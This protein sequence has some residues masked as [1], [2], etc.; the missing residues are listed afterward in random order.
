MTLHNKVIINIIPPGESIP[1]LLSPPLSY[2]MRCLHLF[3]MLTPQTPFPILL[4]TAKLSHYGKRITLCPFCPDKLSLDIC[5]PNKAMR[6][7]AK[8][9]YGTVSPTPTNQKKP[10]KHQKKKLLGCCRSQHRP[11]WPPKS[12]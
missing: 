10:Q 12:L 6:T 3:Q 4:I 2:L 5:I 7:L 8:I 9:S 1:Y 11:Y